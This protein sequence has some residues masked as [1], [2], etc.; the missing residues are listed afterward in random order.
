MDV[1]PVPSISDAKDSLRSIVALRGRLDALLVA[2]NL[3]DGH[4]FTLVEWLRTLPETLVVGGGLR[5]RF[6]PVVPMCAYPT[7]DSM[8]W[9]HRIDASIKCIQKPFH[10]RNAIRAL[11]FAIGTYR[12]DV[13]IEL[14]RAGLAIT[15]DNNRFEIVEGYMTRPFALVQTKLVDSTFDEAGQ[16]CRRMV[17]S[18]E[19]ASTGAIAVEE[20]EEMLNDPRSTETAMHSFFERHPEFLADQNYSWHWS[21]LTLR[22]DTTS[23]EIRP[24]FLFRPLIAHIPWDWNILDLKSPHVKL[25]SYGRFHRDWSSHVHHV[26][27]QLRNYRNFFR[28]ERNRQFLSERFGGV[29][30]RPRL[31][32]VI[33]KDYGEIQSV[34][35]LVEDLVDVRIRTYDELLTFQREQIYRLRSALDG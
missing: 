14:D 35:D 27:R 21:E 23:N 13:M 32:A 24:D 15:Y 5:C 30:P 29:V 11:D 9:L 1:V 19:R 34:A 10:H 2:D 17:L 31:T 6:V 4:G 28:D 3:R 8:R 20:L 16:L 33:G 26:V 7:E 12:H 18:A 22:N 25:T